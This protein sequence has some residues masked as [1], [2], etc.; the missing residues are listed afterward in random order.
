MM[1]HLLI[2]LDNYRQFF[3]PP[4][5]SVSYSDM[6]QFCKSWGRLSTVKHLLAKSYM[7][8]H[9]MMYDQNEMTLW[10]IL[11]LVVLVTFKSISNH[12]RISLEK[13][14]K[15]LPDLAISRYKWAPVSCSVAAAFHLAI[16]VCTSSSDKELI[17]A[18]KACVLTD[19]LH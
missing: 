18:D 9:Q 6:N 3:I 15:R 12:N 16:C 19:A 10:M 2:S 14:W 13:Q 8:M 1:I 4:R 5:E 7:N 17:G 11:A